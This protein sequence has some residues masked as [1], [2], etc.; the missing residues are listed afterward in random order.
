MAKAPDL[1][2]D[3]LPDVVREVIEPH[4]VDSD[5]VLQEISAAIAARRT[6]AVSARESSGIEEV[7]R[8][9]EE[10]YAGI[11]NAN[12]DDSNGKFAKPPSI[13]GPLTRAGAERAAAQAEEGPRAPLSRGPRPLTSRRARRSRGAAR[14]SSS[15][16]AP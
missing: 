2:L 16:S 13:D 9:C 14:L 1:K 15:R 3:E 4:I 8:A 12:R 7:W 6:E 10:A 5:A 11:D